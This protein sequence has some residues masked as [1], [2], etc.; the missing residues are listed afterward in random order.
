MAVE[1]N[2]LEVFENLK[3]FF[4]LQGITTLEMFYQ[5]K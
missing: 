1:V 4:M 2:L 3:V 5:M